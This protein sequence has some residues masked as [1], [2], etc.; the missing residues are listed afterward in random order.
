MYKEKESSR[1]KKNSRAL[2]AVTSG[3]TTPEYFLLVVE[4]VMH[5]S[6]DD[7]L[8]KFSTSSSRLFY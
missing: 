1:Q 6:L 2:S 3:V 5:L 8:A 7:T 4:G